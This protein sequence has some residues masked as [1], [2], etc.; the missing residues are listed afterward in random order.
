[1][2]CACQQQKEKWSESEWVEAM[3][4]TYNP[5]RLRFIAAHLLISLHFTAFRSFHS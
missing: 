3:T 5:Q 2:N 1:M 4:Q